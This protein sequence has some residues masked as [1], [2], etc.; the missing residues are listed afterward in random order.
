MEAR[1]EAESTSTRNSDLAILACQAAIELDNVILRRSTPRHAVRD[2]ASKIREAVNVPDPALPSSLLDP[3]T[4]VALNRAIGGLTTLDELL[5]RAQQVSE[6]LL[7]VSSLTVASVGNEEWE[8]L[9]RFC[10]AL[11]R[12]AASLRQAPDERSH[13]PLRR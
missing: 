12:H 6:R 7:H 9:R 11:S 1:T 4:T 8:E 3:N 13:H 10:L 5:E 2:L